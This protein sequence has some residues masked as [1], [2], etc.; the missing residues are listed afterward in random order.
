MAVKKNESA[1]RLLLCINAVLQK[2]AKNI[3]VLNVKEI[4]SF[5]DYMLICSGSTD[6]QVQAISSAIQEY[7]KKEDIRPLGVEGESNAEWILLDYDDVVIS[8]FQDEARS[9]YGL[10]DL[11]D[12]PR[13]EIDEKATEIKKLTKDMA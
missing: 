2:K 8:V 6:R 11:W 4:S 12:A 5:T 10:E 7:L 1:R 3:V 9:F 13:M